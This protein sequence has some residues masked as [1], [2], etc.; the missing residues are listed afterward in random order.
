M[1]AVISAFRAVIE[2][3]EITI[4]V[5][6][7]FPRNIICLIKLLILG[8]IRFI[9]ANLLPHFTA[10]MLYTL[11]YLVQVVP[12]FISGTLMLFFVSFVWLIDKF[13]GNWSNSTTDS[14]GRLGIMARSFVQLFTTCF[15]DPRS[16]YLTDRYHKGNRHERLLGVYP[17]MS[18]CKGIYQNYLG[19]VLCKR[20]PKTSPQYCPLAAITRSV[21]DKP[22]VPMAKYALNEKACDDESYRTDAQKQLALVACSQP[23]YYNSDTRKFM[24]TA[25]Y[26]RF[27]S[28]NPS[29]DQS[30]SGCTDLIPFKGRQDDI[31]MR[32]LQIPA[33]LIAGVQ[34]FYMLSTSIQVKQDEYVQQNRQ[35]LSQRFTLTKEIT[36]QQ[37]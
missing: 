35:W 4:K 31:K 13:F 34:L 16:W 26:E 17:C 32:V 25:C 29:G 22:Y 27:C 28:N 11:P 8:V 6:T 33:L 9:F 1:G 21:E 15:N 19:G 30:I 36:D 2:V 24:R 12:K 7:G 20:A 37:A 14:G 23:F 18:P 10:I 3:F 5:I